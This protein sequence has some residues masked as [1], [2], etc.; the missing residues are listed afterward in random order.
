MG[1]PVG[2]GV[3]RRL[4]DPGMP[5]YCP[6]S[7]HAVFTNLPAGNNTVTIMVRG[8]FAG[9]VCINR[10]RMPRRLVVKEVLAR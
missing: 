3:L 9:Q 2:R 5:F 4:P 8:E 6:V 1:R 7:A 10:D